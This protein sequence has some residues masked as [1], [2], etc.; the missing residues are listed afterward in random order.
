VTKAPR[1]TVLLAPGALYLFWTTGVFYVFELAGDYD[2]VLLVNEHYRQ[3]DAFNRLVDE[4]PTVRAYF[5]PSLRPVRRLHRFY[6][7]EVRRI[8]EEFRPRFILSNDI[9]GMEMSYLFHFGRLQQSRGDPCA[10]VAIQ[11]SNVATDFEK[12]FAE[13]RN[14]HAGYYVRKYRMPRFLASWLVTALM[15]TFRVLNTFL[16]PTVYAGKPLQPWKTLAPVT[17]QRDSLG[18]FD[19]FLYYTDAEGDVIRQWF[20]ESCCFQKVLHPLRSHESAARRLLQA[21]AEDASIVILPSYVSVSMLRNDLGLTEQ[22]AIESLSNRWSEIITRLRRRFPSYAVRWKIHPLAARDPHWLAVTERVR[23]AAP[24]MEIVDPAEKAEKLILE[25]RVIVGDIST[26][27]AWGGLLSTKIVIS[28]NV[29]GLKYPEMG[30][31][32]NIRY[33]DDMDAFERASFDKSQAG[34]TSGSR[35]IPTVREY[36]AQVMSGA[37]LLPPGEPSR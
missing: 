1:P 20:A 9:W 18:K 14:V 2:V 32:E 31:R 37:A 16:Y 19:A 26:A 15:H 35:H 17:S 33:F 13:G 28:F 12:D 30:G 24:T 11:A 25:S 7:T 23:S 3:S 22:A 10:R 8:V 27:L 6:A 4:H 5:V 36:F 29:F 34:G 21:H